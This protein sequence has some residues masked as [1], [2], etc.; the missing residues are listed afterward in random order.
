MIFKRKNKRKKERLYIDFRYNWKIF[1]SFL[2][3][4]KL[5]VV[6]LLFLVLILEAEQIANKYLFK[7]VIDYGTSFIAGSTPYEAVTKVLIYVAAAFLFLTLIGVIANWFKEHFLI[8]LENNLIVDLKRRFFNH[9]VTLDHEFHVTHKTGSLISRLKRGSGAIEG[10]LDILIFNFAPLVLQLVIAS[11]SLIYF[12]WISAFVILITTIVF[13]AF[14][15]YMQKAQEES[16]II[17]NKTEDIEKGNTADIFTNIDSIRYFGKEDQIKT[18][19]RRLTE[20]TKEAFKRNWDYH[21]ILTAGQSFIIGI[22]TFFLLLFPIL[23]FLEGKLTVGTL[24]FIY[25]VYVGLVGPMFGFVHGIRAYYRAMADFQELFEYAKIEKKITDKPGAK[26]IQINDGEIEFRNVDFNYGS[27]RIFR[28][29]NLKIPRNKKVAF[30]G[31]SGCGKTTLIKLLYRLYDVHKGQVTVDGKD[32]RDI[33]Q[34]SLREEMSIVPQEAIL[35]DDTI[36]NNV[37]FSNQKASR[38]DVVKAIKFAQLDKIIKRF[39]NKE[40]TVV[41]ERG[42]K[43]S[44]GEKQRV[45]IARAILANRKILILDEATSALDSETEHEIQ[46]DL[47]RLMQGRTSIIIAHR[48]STIMHADIIVVMK[49]GKIEQMGTHRDLITQGGEY[50]RLWDFQKGGYIQ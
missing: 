19:Y 41:G 48:L 29:F 18:K 25:S 17:S 26:N 24:T 31:H 20:D 39:P 32:I 21:K 13:I 10:M 1:L 22:G 40:Q 16:R 35:F 11:I 36:Y 9:L 33:K 8:R 47:Q 14:N 43:L 6:I 49:N 4:Y 34:D 3:N 37:A 5:A 15:L 7:I 46:K 27:R 28:D 45:S 38:E 2:K 12:D 42:V 30:V 44:G 23:S 50:Q